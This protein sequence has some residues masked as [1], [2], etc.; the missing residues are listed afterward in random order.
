[1][2]A[3]EIIQ[4]RDFKPSD[5]RKVMEIEHEAFKDPY[6]RSLLEHIREL[7]PD[8]FMVAEINGEIVGYII[9]VMR[10]G[11]EGHIL[12][13]AVAPLYRRKGVGTSLMVNMMERLRREGAN[14]IRIEARA[15]NEGAQEFYR[16][17]NF[18]ER[19][20]V[21]SYYSDGEAA[22]LMRKKLQH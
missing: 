16:K 6:P 22:V 19:K 1:M 3:Q 4:V 11:G 7:H 12:A 14:S 20:L 13:V 10:W 8:G 2:V 15:S 5:M 17:L 9:G 21:P 18:K